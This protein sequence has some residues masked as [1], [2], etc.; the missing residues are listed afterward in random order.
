M[1]TGFKNILHKIDNHKNIPA[2]FANRQL[3]PMLQHNLQMQQAV[4]KQ[5]VSYL[6]GLICI[7]NSNLL[8]LFC[9]TIQL[10]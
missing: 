1:K 5:N 8:K 2:N 7:K 6:I 9:Q 4:S 3:H 10:K